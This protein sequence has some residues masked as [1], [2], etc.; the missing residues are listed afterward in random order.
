MSSPQIRRSWIVVA[1]VAV[2]VGGA[3]VWRFT[4]ESADDLIERLGGTVTKTYFGSQ[5]VERGL[6]YVPGGGRLLRN[7]STPVAAD[8]RRTAVGD[9]EVREIARLDQLHT[10]LLDRTAISDRACRSLAGLREL[11]VLTMSETAV[12]DEGLYYLRNSTRLTV[13]DLDETRVTGAGLRHLQGMV[14]L[15]E[16]SLSGTGVTGPH[17][18]HLSALPNLQFLDLS[19]TPVND[20][21]IE[22]L[23]GLSAVTLLLRDTQITE[24]GLARLRLAN[25]IVGLDLSGTRVNDDVFDHFLRYPDLGRV[26]LTNTQVTKAGIEQF[27]KRTTLIDVQVDWWVRAGQ[28]PD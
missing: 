26:N 27:F 7:L 25:R 12:G 1:V 18:A 23:R 21:D 9:D 10:V 11:R 14:N 24:D 22:R 13:L 6:G 5:W 15:K 19:G 4:G 3:I 17:L 2:L 20:D 8:V 16:L 28:P